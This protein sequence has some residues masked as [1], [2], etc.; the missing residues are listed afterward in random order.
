MKAEAEG[1]E[2]QTNCAQQRGYRTAGLSGSGLL[3]TAVRE[4]EKRG[5]GPKAPVSETESV[6]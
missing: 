6:A 5:A 4:E 1:K 3:Q 2:A